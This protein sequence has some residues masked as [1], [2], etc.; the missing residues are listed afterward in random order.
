[1]DN[2]NDMMVFVLVVEGGSF[3]KAAERMGLPKSNI[4]RKITRLEESLGIRL[5]ERTTRQLHLTEA[6]TVY[7]QHCQRIREEL[8]YA[9]AS[10]N[11]LLDE[12]QGLI[13]VSASV[14]VGQ[15]VI[16]PNI[17]TFLEQY[18]KVNLELELTNRRV[19]LISEGLD[20]VIRVGELQDSTLIAKK[21]GKSQRG[22]YAS[23]IYLAEHKPLINPQQLES[24]AVLYMQ[25]DHQKRQWSLHGNDKKVTIEVNPRL[26]IN[27]FS[28]LLQS[29]QNG[30]GV[31]V[32][33]DYIAQDSVIK[34]QL[35]RVLPEWHLSEVDFYA[36]YPSHRGATPKV[37]AFLDH[38]SSVF[39][40]VL[41]Q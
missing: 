40:N 4:S 24:H 19:D 34:G 14:T 10:V 35:K 23:P 36:V 15:Q 41:M 22:L 20:V 21:L 13:R 32:L 25:T 28:S 31:S 18:P 39:E 30:L 11:S 2:L 33:P 6:G 5:L 26:L 38:F 12:P 3:T 9:K 27:D 29:T 16:S 1:M 17:Q 8:D 37:R 7:Y